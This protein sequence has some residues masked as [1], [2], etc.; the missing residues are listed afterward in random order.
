LLGYALALAG[1]LAIVGPTPFVEQAAPILI[2]LTAT[3]YILAVGL[4]TMHF[5]WQPLALLIG[6]P[7]LGGTYLFCT[8]M[9]MGRGAAFGVP[10]IALGVAC[11]WFG[12][13]GFRLLQR[14]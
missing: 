10:L 2:L 8:T 4:S 5:D 6:L 14:S 7:F 9:I 12:L 13:S 11:A 1:A 3:G